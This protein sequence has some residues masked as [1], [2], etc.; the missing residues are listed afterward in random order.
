MFFSLNYGF[1]GWRVALKHCKLDSEGQFEKSDTTLYLES[2][3]LSKFFIMPVKK[4]I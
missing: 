4:L 1:E 2:L 3:K